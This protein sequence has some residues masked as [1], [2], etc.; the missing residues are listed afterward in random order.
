MEA[1]IPVLGNSKHELFALQIAQGKSAS[2]AYV[3]AGYAKN[4][5]NAGRLNRNEQVRARV[6][7]LLS[8]AAEKAGVTIDRIVAELAKIGF[9]NANDYFEWGPDGVTIKPSAD[10]TL[11]QMSVVGEVQETRAKGHGESTIRIKL[12]DKQAALEKLG[13]HLGMFREKV[14]VTG[15]AGGPI[16]TKD[17][18]A[19]ELIAGRLA[20]I[21]S[22]DGAGGNPG[23]L[24][25]Q[26]G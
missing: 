23:Q 7:E 12:S 24:V 3:A 4:D 10:L 25:R 16:E 5:G 6:D 11:D 1:Q 8:V 9:A 15:A 2:A 17:V 20:G 21:A 22:R 19:R 26:A 13:R 18:S 14:E